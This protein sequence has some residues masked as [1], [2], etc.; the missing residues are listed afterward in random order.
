M[1]TTS[2]NGAEQM[3]SRERILAVLNGKDV[4]RFPVWLKMANPTWKS[5]QPE[6]YHSMD[7]LELLRQADC[8][9]MMGCGLPGGALKAE[10]PHVQTRVE[11]EGNIRHTITETPDGPL[12]GKVARETVTNTSH[13]VGFCADTLDGLRRLRWCY[14]D[15]TYTVDESVA[16]QG[17]ECQRELEAEDIFTMSGIGPAPLMDLVEHLC[18]PEAYAY[19]M[20]D[21]PALFA[22]TLE[23]MHQDRL[24]QLQA[25]LPHVPSDTFWMSE[26]TSTTLISPT[27]FERHCV[28]HL[29]AYGRLILEHGLIPVHHMCGTLNALLETIDALPAMANEAYT[30]PPVGDTTLAEGRTRMP[31]KAL[32]GGTNA[33]L[34]LEPAE[35]IVEAVA[36]DLANCP[37]RRRIFLTSAGVLPPPVTFEKAKAVVAGLKR[38]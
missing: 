1:S 22:E 18:G 32:I 29:A 26:N 12:V 6:P 34:W 9:V 16:Q 19:H 8:D 5:T 28:P 10:R 20:Y 36:E 21:D 14:T 33:T 15:T 30:T 7:G 24:R 35:R 4:D 25:M 13:P 11:T 3:S 2:A 17:A 38:L 37:D 23:I 27:V 31:S